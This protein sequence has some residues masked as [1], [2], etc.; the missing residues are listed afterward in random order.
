[1]PQ[2]GQF[3]S[4]H[5]RQQGFLRKYRVSTG[6]VIC[7]MTHIQMKSY[8]WEKDQN[9]SLKDIF[10]ATVTQVVCPCVNP[11]TAREIIS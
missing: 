11:F 2:P 5:G 3:S 9:P 1:M 10:S 7:I 6:Y 4:L 8:F